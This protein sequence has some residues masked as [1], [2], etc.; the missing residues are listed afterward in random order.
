M[1]RIFYFSS[2]YHRSIF[3][4]SLLLVLLFFS[5]IT[6]KQNKNLIYENNIAVL[7]YLSDSILSRILNGDC[8]LSELSQ[9]DFEKIDIL[10]KKCMEEYNSKQQIKYDEYNL[11]FPK[12]KIDKY[13]FLLKEIEYYNRQ[14][15]CALNGEGEKLVWINCFPKYYSDSY[16][17]SEIVFVLDGGTDYFQLII[18][19]TKG[20][21]YGPAVNGHA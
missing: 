11:K 20:I 7:P 15:I 3:S 17:R 9:D 2:K 6:K 12:Q 19:L 18:N 13:Y 8:E 4:I 16:W 5:C 14:Y 10:M 21:Y 1:L